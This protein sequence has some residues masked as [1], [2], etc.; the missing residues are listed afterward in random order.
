MT[1]SR[2]EV[3]QA[4]LLD[5]L[6]RRLHPCPL[7]EA[8]VTA[9]H[10]HAA[11]VLDTAWKVVAWNCD[12]DELHVL[13]LLAEATAA[14]GGREHRAAD[15]ISCAPDMTLL[16]RAGQ[17]TAFIMTRDLQDDAVTSET[18]QRLDIPVFLVPPPPLRPGADAD[19]EP[20]VGATIFA[21]RCSWPCARAW[22]AFEAQSPEPP[23]SSAPGLWD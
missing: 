18:A 21:E 9:P 4:A 16:D 7:C 19:E 3:W 8:G 1:R 6:Q 5:H 12:R 13:N 17:P 11:P 2:D 20:R 10:D 22:E 14:E 23:S 15:G